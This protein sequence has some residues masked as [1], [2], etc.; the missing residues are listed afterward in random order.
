MTSTLTSP[1]KHSAPEPGS[2][3]AAGFWSLLHA[4]WTKFRTVRGWLIGMLLAAIVTFALGVLTANATIGC[5]PTKTGRACLPHIPIGPGGEAVNDTF[6]W[7]HQP[8]TGDGTITARVASITGE[9]HSHG[10]STPLTI[11]WAKAGIMVKTST[12]QGSSYAAMLVTPGH[13]VRMQYDFTGD[14]AGSTTDRYL[15]LERKGNS[16]TGYEG[17]DGTRWTPL[18]TVQLSGAPTTVQIG[19]FVTSPPY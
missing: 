6:Y 15:K 14:K 3:A 18:G 2:P 1:R 16:V 13:G 8:L 19:L 17:S 11:P 5:G 4:E 7:V 10:D 12:K 9:L